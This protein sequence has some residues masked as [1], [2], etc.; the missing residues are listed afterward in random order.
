[1]IIYAATNGYIDELP[2]SALRRY[3]LELHRFV[4]NRHPELL[5]TIRAKR[6]LSDALKG[7]VNKVLDEFKGVFVL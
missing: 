4:E 7:A 2:V 1:M 3:E 5:E 6:E